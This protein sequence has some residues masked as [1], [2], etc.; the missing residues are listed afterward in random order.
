MQSDNIEYEIY[1][2][3]YKMCVHFMCTFVHFVN[4]SGNCTATV[5]NKSISVFNIYIH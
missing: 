3:T 1:E 2:Y 4:S 5:C